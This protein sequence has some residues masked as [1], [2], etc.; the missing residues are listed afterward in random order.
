M[1]TKEYTPEEIQAWHAKWQ[2]AATTILPEASD[3][4]TPLHSR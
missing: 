4:E 3:K 2:S 1:T